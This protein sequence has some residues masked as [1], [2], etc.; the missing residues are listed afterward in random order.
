MMP[1]KVQ[2]LM[3]AEVS[4]ALPDVPKLLMAWGGFESTEKKK[5]ELKKIHC[6]E[7]MDE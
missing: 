4:F 1:S 6:M 3:A 2:A 5:R 7:K